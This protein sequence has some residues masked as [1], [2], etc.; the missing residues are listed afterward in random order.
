MIKTIADKNIESDDEDGE[1][2]ERSRRAGT[3]VAG[4]TGEG[5]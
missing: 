4:T 1:D 3:S 2:G 5:A